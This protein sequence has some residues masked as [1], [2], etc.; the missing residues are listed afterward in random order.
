MVPVWVT[1][2]SGWLARHKWQ[3]WKSRRILNRNTIPLGSSRAF[4][5]SQ[6]NLWMTIKRSP[7]RLFVGTVGGVGNVS[8]PGFPL[9]CYARVQTPNNLNCQTNSVAGALSQA[10]IETKFYYINYIQHLT[11]HTSYTLCA[12]SCE[13]SRMWIDSVTKPPGAI[14]ISRFV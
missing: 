3:Y 10:E 5:P 13:T 11:S 6:V 9:K 8:A 1:L 7:F 14:W 12:E 2:R 4:F